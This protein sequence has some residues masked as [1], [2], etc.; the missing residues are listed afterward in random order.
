MIRFVQAHP[1]YRRI[2]IIELTTRTAEDSR[3]AAPR[4][5]CTGDQTLRARDAGGTGETLDEHGLTAAHLSDIDPAND[6]RSRTS[7]TIIAECDE[8]LGIAR[9]SL[10]RS[11]RPSISRTSIE[12]GSRNSFRSFHSVKGLSAMVGVV[13]AE[14]LAHQMESYLSALRAERVRL[15]TGG[16]E[17]LISGVLMLERVIGARRENRPPPAVDALLADFAALVRLDPRDARPAMAPTAALMPMELDADKTRTLAVALVHGKHVWRFTFVPSPELARR[18]VNVNAV[19]ERLQ[20][21]GDLIHAAPVVLPGGGIAFTFIVATNQAEETFAPWQAD[22]LTYAP[23]VA[24]PTA[25]PTAPSTPSTG[26][27]AS[28]MPPNMV[29]VDLGRLDDLMR[30]VGELVISREARLAELLR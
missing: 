12:A 14:K 28:L 6:C 16:L 2:P 11:K 30:M 26:T 18:N 25:E 29:R 13:E 21:I 22:A 27:T 4:G 15:T 1:T 8:H 23:F 9:Q 5:P 3:S 10:L 24:P 20:A 17:T 7:S 19:R